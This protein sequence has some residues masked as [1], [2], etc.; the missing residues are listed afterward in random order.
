MDVIYFGGEPAADGA[1]DALLRPNAHDNRC[2]LVDLV[3]PFG[4]TNRTSYPTISPLS[5]ARVRSSKRGEAED[6]ATISSRQTA[7]D[8]GPADSSIQLPSRSRIIDIRAT[9]PSVTGARP[10]RTPLVRRSLWTMSIS[11]ICR[12]M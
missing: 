1:A 4:H 8:R 12:V 11:A 2:R 10:S 6:F 5:S 7:H 9:L 3:S